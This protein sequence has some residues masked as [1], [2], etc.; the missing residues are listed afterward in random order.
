MAATVWNRCVHKPLRSA[1]EPM[2]ES[3][4]DQSDAQEDLV[5]KHGQSSDHTKRF[6]QIRVEPAEHGVGQYQSRRDQ[7]PNGDEPGNQ[8]CAKQHKVTMC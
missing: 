8:S 2:V 6:A 5:Q 7:S 1:Q 3:A 4:D